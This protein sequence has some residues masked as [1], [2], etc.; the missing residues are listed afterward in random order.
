MSAVVFCLTA[1]CIASVAI[2]L[3]AWV[4]HWL[5]AAVALVTGNKCLA[6]NGVAVNTFAILIPA[7]N[8][9]ATI[10]QTLE[11]C[12]ALS[13][14]KEKV[15][16]YVVAD[17]CTDRTAEVAGQL[18]AVC[19]VR[20]DR[21]RRGKGFA[22]EWALP[23]VLAGAHDAVVILDADCL[24]D[25]QSL[26]KL[27][28]RLGA[29]A[30]VLQLDNRVANPDKNATSYLLAIANK[31]ENE[32]FYAPKSRLGLAVNL[33]GT[34]MAFYRSILQQFPWHACSAAEDAEYG[35]RLFRAGVSIE[36][37]PQCGVVSNSPVNRRQLKVQR[38]RWIAGAWRLACTQGIAM[39]LEGL[40]TRRQILVDAAFTLFVQSRPL[41]ILQLLATTA[42]STFL[43]FLAPGRISAALLATCGVIGAGYF[44]Y[45]I[46]GA[47][48]LGLTRRR[49]GMLLCLPGVAFGYLI[50]A[51]R[52]LTSFATVSW[53]RTPRS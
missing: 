42:A 13:Y 16:V 27:D 40:R 51:I 49:L 20:E 31:L 6:A 23:Q 50:M 32:L 36:F 25:S 10:R 15:A 3:A 37:V 14:P 46:L 19:L 8:E 2:A 44:F 9:E 35:Y 33:R 29:G 34:G 28:A 12:A 41:V 43:F 38:T 21:E 11:S 39:L 1:I 53:T 26:A 47:L 48:M 45:G 52:P 22:L 24:I 4:Y 5:L 18:G 17:N 30:R 7:H